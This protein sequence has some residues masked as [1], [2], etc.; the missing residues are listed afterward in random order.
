MWL[1]PGSERRSAR[2][3]T[4]YSD[5]HGL[6]SAPQRESPGQRRGIRR[7]GFLGSVTKQRLVPDCPMIKK[8]PL[9]MAAVHNTCQ[10]DALRRSIRV[11][12]IDVGHLACSR[13]QRSDFTTEMEVF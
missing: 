8:S 6:H 1:I 5:T 10:G 11:P 13:L 7:L 4:S 2:F 12:D 9:R 3:V